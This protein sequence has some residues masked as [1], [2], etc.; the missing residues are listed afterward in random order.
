MD[1]SAWMVIFGENT[2][3]DLTGIV[4]GTFGEEDNYLT[5]FGVRTLTY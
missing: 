2:F 1:V 4:D 3:A 5:E